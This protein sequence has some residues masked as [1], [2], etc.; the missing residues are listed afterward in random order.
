MKGTCT[1]SVTS[2]ICSIWHKIS[3]IKILH[4]MPSINVKIKL[5]KKWL[6]AW[7]TLSTLTPVVGIPFGLVVAHFLLSG[8]LECIFGIRKVISGLAHLGTFYFFW[9][10]PFRSKAFGSEHWSIGFGSHLS[11]LDITIFSWFYILESFSWSIIFFYWKLPKTS[12]YK[13]GT[14]KNIQN[15]F[16]DYIL[17]FVHTFLL[18]PV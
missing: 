6:I 4:P 2:T 7:N 5:N 17:L 3:S 15:H 12:K 11:Y 1:L 8:A 9:Y 16:F 10:K 14:L 18:I 13:S